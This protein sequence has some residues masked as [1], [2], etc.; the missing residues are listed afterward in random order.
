MRHCAAARRMPP[1]HAA[2]MGDACRSY[3]GSTPGGH[4]PSSWRAVLPSHHIESPIEDR[5]LVFLLTLVL[6]TLHE[7]AS[8]QGSAGQKHT[9]R[10]GDPR[11]AV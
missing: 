10:P 3:C 5:V 1:E 11:P 4:D 7:S 6:N 2:C 8:R 9:F